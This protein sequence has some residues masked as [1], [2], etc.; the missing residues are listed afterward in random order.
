MPSQDLFD[1][2][3]HRLS[4]IRLL[5]LAEVRHIT[6]YIR[7]LEESTN[8]NR[9]D[10][11][12]PERTGQQRHTNQEETEFARAERLF[13]E[14]RGYLVDRRTE[15]RAGRTESQAG[16]PERPIVTNVNNRRTQRALRN[17]RRARQVN[18]R[19]HRA[20]QV[21]QR[22]SR[23]QAENILRTSHR[24][25][26]TPLTRRPDAPHFEQAG[27]TVLNQLVDLFVEE[28][29]RQV[30][31]EGDTRRVNTQVRTVQNSR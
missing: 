4:E 22:H 11:R 14:E 15:A 5:R 3:I 21:N 1:N 10:T 20:R 23:P 26:N 25:G 30:D 8:S 16:R 17:S 18:R 9:T 24:V 31:P 29:V 13:I 2:I 12:R 28:I 6:N 7:A 27:P 19:N